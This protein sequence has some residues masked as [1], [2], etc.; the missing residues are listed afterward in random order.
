KDEE[1][2]DTAGGELPGKDMNK[3]L[4]KLLG[5]L[6]VRLLTKVGTGLTLIGPE[7]AGAFEGKNV[8]EASRRL[9]QLGLVEL[10]E[11]DDKGRIGIRLT[12]LGRRVV[13]G[14]S[15]SGAEHRSVGRAE[16]R[17]GVRDR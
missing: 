8:S 13:A 3:L 4:G 11:P 5:D 12:R 2:K 7:T 10:R 14:L 15:K 1:Q 16:K 9:Q 17:R 6:E